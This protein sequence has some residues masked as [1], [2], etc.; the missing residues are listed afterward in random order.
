[1]IKA[2]APLKS[3]TRL[4]VDARRRFD[5]LVRSSQLAR[6][7]LRLS[8][9]DRNQAAD[10]DDL[11]EDADLW[12]ARRLLQTCLAWWITLTRNHLERSANAVAAS[13]RVLVQK[14]WERWRAESLRGMEAARIGA[15][16][17]RVR[18]TLTAFRQWKRRA[19]T[20]AERKEEL[21]KGSMRTAY[22]TTTAKVKK[23]M[24][25][26]AF[27]IWGN[28]HQINTADNI[29]RN[30]LQ[31]GA[32]ALW[33][34]RS[35]QCKQLYTREKTIKVKQNHSTL[36]RAWD[37][38]SD[39][40]DQAQLVGQFQQRHH[41][42]LALNALHVWR[43]RTTLSSLSNEFTQRRLKLAALDS[44]KVALV[45][46]RLHRKQ[47]ALANRWRA[48]RLKRTA[49]LSWRQSSQKLSAMQQQADTMRHEIQQDQMQ[50]ALHRWQLKSRAALLARVRTAGIVERA[51]QHWKQRHTALMTSLNQ[52]EST[53]V[54]RRQETVK[55]ACF[56]RWD[57]LTK[58]LRDREAHV[59]AQKNEILCIDVFVTWRNKLLEQ[60][61]LQQKS[62]AVSGFFTLRSALRQWRSKLREHRADA[63]EA[64]HERR[65]VHQVFEIWRSR[66]AKQR[67]LANT[68]QQ[69]LIKKDET[70]ARAYLSQ[71]VARIIEVRNRELEVKEQRQRRLVKAAFYAWIEACLRHDDLLALMNS[72]VDVKEEDRKRQTFSRWLNFAREQ[73]DRREK[74]EMLARSSQTKLLAATWSAWQ[75][76]VKERS[77]AVH[78]YEML[79]RRQQLTKQW[80]LRSWQSR[81][82]LLP[83]IRMR[84]TSLKRTTLQRW[85]ER[86]PMRNCPTRRAKFS[87]PKRC[88]AAGKLG[89]PMR[90]LS[91]NCVL[92]RGSEL[93]ASHWQGCGRCRLRVARDRRL[94]WQRTRRA[95]R[96]VSRR[97]G[98][99]PV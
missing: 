47:E 62:L 15:K 55:A 64:N 75:D 7:R 86:L 46:R 59:Q 22:Y 5:E 51:F 53:I 42:Q 40:A 93:A 6:S 65:L 60:R 18:C 1:M 68:L 12:R 24:L 14:A 92:Q 69:V 78:E 97:D 56:E 71:W 74:A 39:K 61:L 79:L 44:W 17:D 35:S 76:K 94:P 11:V 29:R 81:T 31:S 4:P 95:L 77:L 19:H 43:E 73:R 84:N 70:L 82:L 34:M 10:T 26:D 98:R 28:R 99:R 25:E 32:F 91:G 89:W 96:A 33:Q 58:Q 13:D 83:A 63:K 38:W 80:A 30:H 54:A 67:R 2:L 57:R 45:Q 9:V 3:A 23:R 50:S 49:L 66:A 48:R 27:T 36:A 8:Q 88:N 20:A 21:K 37:R 85:R 52:R 16:T 72:Y 87:G 41:Q 90:K